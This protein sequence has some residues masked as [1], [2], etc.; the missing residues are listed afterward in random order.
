MGNNQTEHIRI[1]GLAILNRPKSGYWLDQA[2]Q[3]KV[4]GRTNQT[5]KRVLVRP[6]RPNYGYWAE[7]SDLIMSIGQIESP[8]NGY[9]PDQTGCNM[10]IDQTDQTE[11]WVLARPNGPEY[12]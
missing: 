12:G 11:L 5:K 1:W 10:D 9:W 3:N 8:K 6:N 2:N 7:R 4:H